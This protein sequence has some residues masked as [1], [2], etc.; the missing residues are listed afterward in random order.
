MLS[1]AAGEQSTGCLFQPLLLVHGMA[2]APVAQEKR[3][4][5]LLYVLLGIIL[6]GAL[7]G[8]LA[9]LVLT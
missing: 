8:L 3:N 2:E 6:L 9:S 5:G 4:R 7:S 1:T